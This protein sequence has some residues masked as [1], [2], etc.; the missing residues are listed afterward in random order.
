MKKY[1]FTFTFALLFVTGL[2]SQLQYSKVRISLQGIE[3]GSIAAL[4]IDLNEGILKK[5]AYFETDL[6]DF[7]IDKLTIPWYHYRDYYR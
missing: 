5:G 7:Q 1:I 6:S 4:G 2:F 3:L